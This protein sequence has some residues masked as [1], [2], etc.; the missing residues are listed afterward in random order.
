LVALRY[1]VRVC[2]MTEIAITKLDVL[3]SLD[4][5]KICVAY[6]HAGRVLE[7]FPPDTHVLE[8]CE[9]VYESLPGWTSDIQ[10]VRAR[11]ELPAEALAYLQ[12]IEAACG[13]PVRIVSVGPKRAQTIFEP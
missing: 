8:G 4:P 6:R 10:P 12:R 5:L 11:A 2:G 1:A 9:P 13:I 3:T 7:H